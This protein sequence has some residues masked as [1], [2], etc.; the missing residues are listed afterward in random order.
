MSH[1]QTASSPGPNSP[2]GEGPGDK[3]SS[4]TTLTLALTL[5]RSH[6]V[7]LQL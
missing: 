6:T 4:H 3:P 1:S 7:F 2:Q 5:C